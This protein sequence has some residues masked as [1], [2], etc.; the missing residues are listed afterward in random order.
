MIAVFEWLDARPLLYGTIAWGSLGL[1]VTA[2]AL[3]APAGAGPGWRKWAGHPLVFAS[4]VLLVLGAFRW[5]TWF[6]AEEFNPDESQLLAGAITLKQYL[7][8][9]KY[10]DGATHGPICEYLLVLASWL[11]A[12]L[13]HATARIMGTALQ[14][15]SLIAVWRVLGSLTTERA[16]RF[17]ILPGLAFWAFITWTDFLHYASSLP[18]IAVL[19]LA[20]WALVQ[21]L[22]AAA[23]ERATLPRLYAGGLA[24]GLIPLTKLQ[25]AP[26][27]VSLA[28]FAVGW[29]GYRG[30]RQKAP[31]FGRPMACLIAGGLTP[32]LLLLAYLGTFGLAS[33][34]WYSYIISALDYSGSG[35]HPFREM[36]SWFFRFSA[37]SFAFSWFFWGGLAF[38]LLF[39]RSPCPQPARLA[40]LLA[41]GVLA[42]AIFCVLRPCREV[43]H[44]LHI[45]VVPTTFLCGL[46]LAGA[47][48]GS[49]DTKL[50]LIGPY[51][52]FLL[53]T[54]LPQVHF[55]ASSGIVFVGHLNE[56]LAK[57]PSAVARYISQHQQPGDALVMWG[58]DPTLFVETGL[59]QGTREACIPY[60]LASWPLQ[61]F[62]IDRFVRDMT[63]RRP[64]W[65]VDAVSPGSFVYEDRKIHGHERTAPV[66]EIIGR[67]YVFCAEF[68]SRRIYRLKESATPA[69]FADQP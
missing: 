2:A 33:Q 39:A 15:L 57:P 46:V 50:R 40:R 13:T 17:G 21:P 4:L 18:G 62:Y 29:L 34:F 54:V 53:L 48:A 22:V 16:A 32:L 36:G 49:P 31:V 6:V 69:R 51:V 7:V 66:A 37:S 42:V 59:P 55:R 35:Q 8:Y 41:W 68:N 67:D 52:A 38:A 63:T 23:P 45:L 5:P 25:L 1:C 9:W 56:Y 27:A 28:L 14:A 64:T 60:L 3:P 26:L 43:A 19:S 20:G 30:W 58:W 24:L 11:G 44:Y 47:Q 61:D 10:V 12:P 65:F